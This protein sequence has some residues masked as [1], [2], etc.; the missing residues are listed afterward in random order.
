MKYYIDRKRHLVCVPYSVENLHLMALDLGIK[1]CW[2]HRTH[3]D[4]PIRRKS[5]IEQKCYIV[6]SKDIVKII[7]KTWTGSSEAEQAALNR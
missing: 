7:N 1:R 6:S 2:F 5:E 3:Y 4:L